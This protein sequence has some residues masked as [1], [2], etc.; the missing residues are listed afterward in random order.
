MRSSRLIAP[1]PDPTTGGSFLD[2]A[3]PA[4]EISRMRS[5]H[6]PTRPLRRIVSALARLSVGLLVLPG[7][8]R[9]GYDTAMTYPV[10]AD[11]LVNPANNWDQ[12]PTVFNTP[13]TLPLDAL[14]LPEHEQP[15]YVRKL[16]GEVGKKI[17]NPDEITAEHRAEIGKALTEF[18][19][20]PAAPKVGGFDL[21]ALKVVDDALTP[22]GV[23]KTLE[24]DEAKL[25]E[26][27]RLY[28]QHCLHC[29]GLSGNGRGPTGYWVNPSPR[30]YRQGVFKFTSSNQDQNLRKPRRA[31]LLHVL[32]MGIDGTSMPSFGV[33][34]RA[35][36]ELLASYVIHLSLRGEVEFLTM[37][38][39]IQNKKPTTPLRDSIDNPTVKQS[40]E[41]YQALAAG[42]WV[43]AQNP[44]AAITPE[45]YPYGDTDSAL[46]ESAARGS[47][48]FAGPGGCIS[49]HQNFGREA[50]LSYD[51]WGTMVRG[52]NLYDGIYRGGRTPVDLYYRIYGGIN[53]AGMTA[54]KDLKS[55]IKP[56]EIGL[57]EEQ[58]AA[59]DPLWDLVNFLRALAYPDMRQRLRE[60]YKVNLPE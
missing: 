23:V 11:W 2:I 37:L 13:G 26:G 41:D 6:S 54:Y 49:C 21:A 3:V 56:E 29:H 14:S 39:L 38:D 28:R 58:M 32:T 9:D 25:A 34:P 1:I 60:Q 46:L 8:T 40:M 20:T 30:D 27:S 44:D 7:C 47:K 24:V 17:F 4:R 19:G 35:E 42:R 50:N 10:R 31:D 53:G 48:L 51:S 16:K 22:D 5:G 43:A 15:E 33:L 36:L 18:F 57:T 59:V 45:N 55:L 12:Q 52:R